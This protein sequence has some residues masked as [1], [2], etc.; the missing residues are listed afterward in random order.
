M[1][2]LNHPVSKPDD[3]SQRYGLEPVPENVARPTKLVAR[4]QAEFEEI[5]KLIAKDTALTA[6]FFRYA[7]PSFEAFAAN[8]SRNISDTMN[9]FHAGLRL[10]AVAAKGA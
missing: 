7:N 6:R 5:G 9:G 4:Q 2:S 10:R 1:P 3:L 8:F